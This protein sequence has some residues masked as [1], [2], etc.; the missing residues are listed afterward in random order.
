VDLVS[1][2][3]SAPVARPVPSTMLNY[4]PTAEQNIVRLWENTLM[5]VDK[6]MQTQTGADE[7]MDTHLDL[8][9]GHITGSVKK[10]SAASKFEVKIPNGVAAIRGTI[11][12]ISAEGVIKVL[13]GAIVLSYVGP[14]GST[15]VQDING[16]QMYDARTGTLTTLPNADK[17]GMEAT[18][19]QM[20][21]GLTSPNMPVS[22]TTTDQ[23]VSP[24]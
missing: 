17:T 16:L 22:G 3:S 7:V 18:S 19:N 14:D 12:D 4:Q 9:A 6:L 21:A 5:G 2:D 13:S 10:M 8:Q 1:G 11:Y 20:Q 24:H 15:K 23:Y